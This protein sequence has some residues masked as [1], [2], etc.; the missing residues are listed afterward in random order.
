MSEEEIE[1]T[2]EPSDNRY[3]KADTVLYV[4]NRKQ[5]LVVTKSEREEKISATR[6][7]EVFDITKEL[8]DGLEQGYFDEQFLNRGWTPPIQR[9]TDE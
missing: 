4:T 6:L 1:M 3:K 8:A 5:W 7:D 9:D 2:E